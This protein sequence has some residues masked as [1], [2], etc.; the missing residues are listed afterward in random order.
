M[1]P[2]VVTVTLL[3]HQA[4]PPEDYRAQLRALEI[5]YWQKDREKEFFD[6]D[7]D[8]VYIEKLKDLAKRAKGTP[9][10]EQALVRAFGMAVRQRNEVLGLALAEECIAANPGSPG[11]WDIAASGWGPSPRVLPWIKVVLRKLMARATDRDVKAASRYRLG[12]LLVFDHKATTDE[13]AEGRKLFEEVK[14]DYHGTKPEDYAALAEGSLFELD[15]LRVGMTAPDFEATDVEGKAFKLS[16][17]RGKMVVLDFWKLNRDA[18][19]HLPDRKELVERMR[20][21]SFV[22]LGID[23]DSPDEWNRSPLKQGLTWRNV[24]DRGKSPLTTRWGIRDWPTQYLLDAKGAIRA[25]SEYWWAT[26]GIVEYDKEGKSRSRDTLS[27]EV[28]KLLEKLEKE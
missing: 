27:V 28:V 2:M 18:Q 13:L 19:R 15:H 10:S 26:Q 21:K 9:W 22:L 5:E 23:F 12:C 6:K 14:K 20:D 24:L 25:K 1:I 3:A 16:D 7:P 17:Y 11:L 8:L 4:T